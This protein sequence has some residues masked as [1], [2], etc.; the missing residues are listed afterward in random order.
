MFVAFASGYFDHKYI[1]SYDEMYGKSFFKIT[2]HFFIQTPFYDKIGM[3]VM[4]TKTE[5]PRVFK[6]NE[7]D[8]DIL[9]MSTFES[10]L[11]LALIATSDSVSLDFT[12]V[13]EIS[14]A[15]LGILLAKKM[16]LKKK[17]IEINLMNVS[18]YLQRIL[19]LLN[20]S[21]YFLPAK[22]Y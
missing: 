7:K 10:E 5:N 20:L 9:S 1:S 17:G 12:E 19:K 8:L 3:I 22:V 21:D 14:S 18:N 4:I 6:V 13:E 2:I 11:D 16:K 15:I